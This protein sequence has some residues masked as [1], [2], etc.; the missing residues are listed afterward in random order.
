MKHKQFRAWHK[1]D[2][3]WATPFE[4]GFALTGIALEE[5]NFY[6]D[7]TGAHEAHE[8]FEINEW[9]GFYDK[10]HVRIHEGDL[11][12]VNGGKQLHAVVFQDG[13]YG[14]DYIGDFEPLSNYRSM[15]V[16]SNVFET[17]KYEGVQYENE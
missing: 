12:R 10:N 6:S 17:P 8:A 4:V 2:G 15:E 1:K 5:S 11:V 13:C 9:T 3:R 16:V 14:S 7:I